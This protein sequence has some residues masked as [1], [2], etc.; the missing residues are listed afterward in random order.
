MA[1][2]SERIAEAYALACR[3]ELRALKPGNVHVHAAGH[4]MS[5]ADFEA[6]CDASAPEIA[7]AGA[8]VGQR[9]LRAVRATRDAVGCNTN[10]GIVLLAA[11]L[12]QAALQEAGRPLRERLR[13][14][15]DSLTV[16][17]AADA[18]QAI[19]LAAP[20]GLGESPRHD[21]RDTPTVTLAEAMVEAA[22]RDTIARQYTSAYADIFE[23]GL[24][25]AVRA[26]DRWRSPDWT[27][28]AVYMDFLAR[29]PDSHVA[30]KF[31]PET[32]EALRLRAAPYRADLL[33]S[34]TP[35]TLSGRL[36]SFD[37]ALKQDGL[38]PGTSADLCVATIFALMLDQGCRNKITVLL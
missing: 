5:V 17:D 29:L 37:A 20:G 28:A 7:R 8:T 32:A 33:G 23:Y 24:P 6:S 30:R 9:I 36:L 25:I 19:R 10:L 31:G 15:L 11:P 35:E 21:V 4:G 38:N 26:L 2:A 3:I 1:G 13:G 22:G 34:E 16:E 27:V 14:V 18:Y 12:A